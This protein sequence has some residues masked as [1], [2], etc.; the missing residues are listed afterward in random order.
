MKFRKS[1]KKSIQ[2]IQDDIFRKM[3]DDKKIRLI[4]D[5]TMF[6]LKLN[7]LNGNNESGKTSLKSSVGFRRT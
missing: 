4:S 5:L 7:C 6:C 1:D 2:K 3:P